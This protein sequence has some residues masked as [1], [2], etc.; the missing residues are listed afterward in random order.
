[1]KLLLD[2]HVFIW[3]IGGDAK[4]SRVARTLIEDTANEK[5]F[6]VASVWEMAIL[7]RLGRITIAGNFEVFIASQLQANTI[8]LSNITLGHLSKVSELPLH[9]RDPFDRLIISQ[10]LVESYAIVS[11]DEMFD[12]YSVTRLW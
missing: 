9:H 4:L 6:S 2:T 12:G 7:K 1:M 5:F 11:I 3:F 10:G 8:A